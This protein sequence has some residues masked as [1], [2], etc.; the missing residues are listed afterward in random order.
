[1]C[2]IIDLDLPTSRTRLESKEIAATVEQHLEENKAEQKAI[3]KRLRE[4]RSK[5]ASYQRF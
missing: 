3:I 5:A 4:L 2:A 1:M